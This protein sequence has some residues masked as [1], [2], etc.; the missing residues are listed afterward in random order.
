MSKVQQTKNTQY[1]QVCIIQIREVLV[2]VMVIYNAIRDT[3]PNIN[4]YAMERSFKLN[5]QYIYRSKPIALNLVN[6]GNSSCTN[7]KRQ[8]FKCDIILTLK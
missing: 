6:L 2:V 3:A 5:Y 1:K 8:D 4:N 7:E